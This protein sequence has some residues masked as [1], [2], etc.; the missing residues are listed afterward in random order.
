MKTIAVFG[1]AVPKPEEMD[2]Q[3]AYELGRALCASG[4]QV[5]TGGYS[6]VMEAVSK[7]GCEVGGHVIGV[8]TALFDATR[9]NG[10]N[11]WVKQEIKYLTLRERL[12]HMI[13]EP[14]GYVAMPGGLGTLNELVMVWELMRVDDIPRRPLICYGQYWERMLA[15]F[16]ESPYIQ[17]TFWDLLTFADTPEEAVAALDGWQNGSKS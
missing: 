6:G 16:V 13:V 7:G 4:Y 2:Y 14:D 10:A 5:M 17:P 8:T 15:N 9:P 12:I 1:S 11:Q 3:H